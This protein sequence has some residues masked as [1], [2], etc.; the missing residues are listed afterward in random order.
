MSN[1]LVIGLSA[2]LAGQ[3]VRF[4]KSHKR[5]NF[6]MDVLSEFVEYKTFC[7]EMAVGL[8][9]PRQTVRQI[10]KDNI[11]TVSRPDGSGDITDALNRYGEQ[12]ATK[13]PNLSG[14][15]F[16]AKS[17]SC[18]MER[19]KVYSEDGRS[20]KKEGVGVF[21]YQIMKHNP[22]LPCEENGRLN[23]PL[24]RENFILRV[25]VYHQWQQLLAKGIT[26]NALFD[27]HASN[28]YLLMAHHV[29]SYKT[30]GRI[31]AEATDDLEPVAER[32]ISGLM[33][34]LSHRATRKT[35]ANTMYHLM[36]YF[37]KELN[38]EQKS[39][40]LDNIEQ[41][42]LGLLP[43]LAPLTLFKHYLKTFPK[44]YLINQRYFDPYPVELKLRYGY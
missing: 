42:R 15:V 44:D 17:P 2:C 9:T 25:F 21:A 30:L 34:A 23:D 12:V 40:L 26:K 43:L 7:P 5:S 19:V 14:F 39:E 8:P 27:F 10:E 41:Y 28:K 35:H 33:S 4:D 24:L 18:G 31:L 22:N 29:E 37:K 6:C 38:Q 36:G 11:I 1:K 16:C 32:Y 20:C 3:E 13:I